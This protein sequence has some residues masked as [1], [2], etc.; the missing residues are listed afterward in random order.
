MQVNEE[1]TITEKGVIHFFL[2]TFGKY[3]SQRIFAI[4]QPF[5]VEARKYNVAAVETYS[6]FCFFL[7]EAADGSVLSD[8]EVGV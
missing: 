6:A 7:I 5:E 3:F 2:I 1:I 4:G 8:A